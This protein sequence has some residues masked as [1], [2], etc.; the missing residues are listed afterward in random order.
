MKRFGFKQI[1][2]I[3]HVIAVILVF[4][5]FC[6]FLAFGV[7][8][9]FDK[10]NRKGQYDN[11][12]F[13]AAFDESRELSRDY[14]HCMADGVV[15]TANLDDF[16]ELASRERGGCAL[17]T[18]NLQRKGFWLPRPGKSGLRLMSCLL[19]LS[20]PRA[21]SSRNSVESR[22]RFVGADH[23]YAHD[24]AGTRP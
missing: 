4:C 20:M 2:E 16:I 22:D 1:A 6:V 7:D 14:I 10:R 12:G 9:F 18:S 21:V 3:E 8:Q 23:A 15:V 24:I 19:P 17:G 5:A 13:G 11:V